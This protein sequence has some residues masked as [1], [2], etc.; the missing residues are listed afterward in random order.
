MDTI[1]PA[2]TLHPRS[3]EF[4]QSQT[5]TQCL[6]VL[7]DVVP[8]RVVPALVYGSIV[9][10]LVG[11]VPTLP[12][13]WKFLLTLVLF[14]MTT[15]SVILFVSIAISNT[16]VAGLVGTLIMLY[17]YVFPP[18]QPSCI[19]QTLASYLLGC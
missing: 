6:Q 19:N 13:F 1:P 12:G 2:L 7:F 3:D 18:L 15:A 9:Y 14:N 5:M 17:K 16:A 10:G 8:L 4:F 11:L